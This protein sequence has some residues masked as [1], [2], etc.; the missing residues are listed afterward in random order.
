M[1][2]SQESVNEAGDA[3]VQ[4]IALYVQ[5]RQFDR[6]LEI[7]ESHRFPDREREG[8]IHDL[9]VDAHLLRGLQSFRKENY[10]AVL[11]DFRAALKYPENLEMGRF[12]NPGRS[13]Q[14]YCMIAHVLEEMGDSGQAEDYYRKALEA[15][16]TEDISETTY[17]RGFALKSLGR[18]EEANAAFQSLIQDGKRS[19]TAGGAIGS[20][21]K[22]GQKESH[23]AEVAK[24]R[25]IQGLGFLGL[26]D[27]RRAEEKFLDALALDPNHV[28]ARAGLN[29]L[30]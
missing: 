1:W 26:G 28:W 21:A 5:T 10:A 17:Y 7:L 24:A 12:S 3:L 29:A 14:I 22:S 25:Y 4:Q 2:A 6:A 30:E 16:Q 8:D 23:D 18:T 20:S 9:Y 15:K 27:V 19:R 13:A 11:S